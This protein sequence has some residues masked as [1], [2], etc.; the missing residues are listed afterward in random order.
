LLPIVIKA[1]TKGNMEGKGFF[2]L[3]FPHLS[4]Q[5]QHSG[6]RGRQISEFEASLVYRVSP[7]T[8]RA[9]QRNPVSEKK[10]RER[11]RKQNKNK[12][13]PHHCLSLKEV[14]TRTQNRSTTWRR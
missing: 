11:E 6:G 5:S 10:E 9:T 2:Q 8:G 1:M 14:R 13:F 3:T 7:R 4:G 12:A